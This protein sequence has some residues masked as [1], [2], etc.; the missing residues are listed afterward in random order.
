MAHTPHLFLAPPWSGESISLSA[1]QSNHLFKALRLG[2]GSPVTYTDGRG[3]FG[4]G[5]L[6]NTHLTRGVENMVSPPI[7]LEIA[8]VPPHERERVRFLVEKAAELEVRRIR[9][10]RSRF[11]NAR[12]SQAARAGEWAIAALEQS[13]GAWLTLVEDDWV[14][15]LDLDPR[16]PTWVADRDGERSVPTPPLRVVV[17]PEGGWAEE[18]LPATWPRLALGRTILRTETAVVAAI[19]AVSSY[20]TNFSGD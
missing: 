15:P 9:W 10:L 20:S 19:V 11:G 14:R 17:G 4:S 6:T 7:D 13:R 16:L 1:Q 3:L 18:E 8:V 2:P 5:E 12:P